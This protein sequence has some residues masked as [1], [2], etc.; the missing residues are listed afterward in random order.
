MI[1]LAISQFFLFGVIF[2]AHAQTENWPNRPIRLIN[3]Y[4][5]GGFGDMVARPMIDRLAQSLGQPIIVESHAGANGSLASSV[6]SKALP[7]GYTVL[8]GNLGPIVINPVLQPT[9]S[10]NTIKSFIPVTQIV[11]GPL[12]FLVHSESNI[13]SINDLIA[14]AKK[15]PHKL[16][17]GS[18]G[19]GSTTHL[20]GELLTL[21]TGVD[22][23]HVPYK[24]A[25][26]A[27]TALLG[28][29]VD[30]AIVNISLSKPHI[31]SGKLRPLA[32]TT[33]KRAA[34]L[35]EVPT[36]AEFI[37]NFEVNPWWGFMVPTGTPQTIVDKLQA[38]TAK[39]LAIPEITERFR[40]YGQEPEGTTQAE[41]T[42]RIKEELAQW[43]EVVKTNHINID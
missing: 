16:S 34:I 8:F 2:A 26:P 12:I 29:Q 24:G 30:V 19:P 35:P 20:A 6:A 32:V 9:T 42:L 5:A 33:M 39:V 40:K 36:V 25:A 10:V 31:E 3:P 43:Q 38:E 11:S 27:I 18:V 23:L 22:M 14:E 17:Y 4:A 21:R 1:R 15:H 28:K 13:R 37:P 41:F 7:D